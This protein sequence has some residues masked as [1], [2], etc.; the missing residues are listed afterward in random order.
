MRFTLIKDIRQDKSIKPMLGGV[1]LFILLY[2][3]ADIFV[4]HSTLGL[5]LSS[6]SLTLFGSEEEF[7]DPMPR[8]V[9]LELIHTEIFMQMMLLLTL[10]AIFNRLRAKKSATL[11]LTNITLMSALLSLI[12]L[13][14]VYFLSPA[15]LSAYIALFFLWH[16][17]AAVMSISSLWELYFAKSV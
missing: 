9:F 15:L 4:K 16:L 10:S 11:V 12:A 17:G 3:I 13:G 6:V 14:S 2:L 1:V 7:I 8:G 5:S